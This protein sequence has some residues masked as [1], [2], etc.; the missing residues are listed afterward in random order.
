VLV[1]M[2]EILS[3]Q[4][5]YSTQLQGIIM[6]NLLDFTTTQTLDSIILMV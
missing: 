5:G 4:D 6:I 1:N 3:L 2:F